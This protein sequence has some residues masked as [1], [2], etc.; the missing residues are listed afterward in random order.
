MQQRNNTFCTFC[1]GRDPNDRLKFTHNVRCAAKGDVTC[2]FLKVTTCTRC[3]KFGHTSKNCTYDAD[4]IELQMT[5]SMCLGEIKH[6]YPWEKG[7][8]KQLQALM[9]RDRLEIESCSVFPMRQKRYYQRL[10][11]M[12]GQADPDFERICCKYC[13]NYNPNDTYYVTHHVAMCPRLACY[14][15][16][17]CGEKGH[18]QTHCPKPEL[19]AIFEKY[20]CEEYIIDFDS[21]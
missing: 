3:F 12:H 8:D 18:T 20:N 14:T 2:P 11:M 16:R 15:C 1:N 5:A 10:A 17:I 21:E 4:M 6:L 7:A 13:Y 9:A 19:D